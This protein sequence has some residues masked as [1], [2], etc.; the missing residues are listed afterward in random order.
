MSH[1]PA[2]QNIGTLSLDNTVA[3]EQP[4]SGSDAAFYYWA[5]VLGSLTIFSKL[6]L[7]AFI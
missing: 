6:L 4:S 3:W 1:M 5:T 2:Q 7:D